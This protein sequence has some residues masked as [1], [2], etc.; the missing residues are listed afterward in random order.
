MKNI[1]M[2]IFGW[3]SSSWNEEKYVEKKNGAETGNGLLPI[4]C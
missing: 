4:W 2:Y 3:F 1:Y